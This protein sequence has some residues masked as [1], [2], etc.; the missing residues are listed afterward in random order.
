[1]QIALLDGLF[2]LLFAHPQR[3]QVPTWVIITLLLHLKVIATYRIEEI[4]STYNHVENF[5]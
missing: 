2:S 5:L 3:E 1:M 4:P